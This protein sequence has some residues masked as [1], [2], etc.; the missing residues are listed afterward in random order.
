MSTAPAAQFKQRSSDRAVRAPQQN[1]A[2]ALP[3]LRQYPNGGQ[4]R[5]VCGRHRGLFGGLF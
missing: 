4:D 2:I 1:A 5:K 3:C